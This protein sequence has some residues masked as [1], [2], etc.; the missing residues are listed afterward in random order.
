MAEAALVASS[1]QFSDMANAAPAMI[2]TT[3]S[4]GVTTFVSSLW[5][6]T[7]GQ[8]GDQPLGRENHAG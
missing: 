5:C 3:D 8:R 6:E 1:R 2:W 7:T 4:T